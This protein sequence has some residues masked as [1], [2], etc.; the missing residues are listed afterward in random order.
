METL[1]VGTGYIRPMIIGG[2]RVERSY[3]PWAAII[4]IDGSIICGG[5]L[6]T[7]NHVLTAAHCVYGQVFTNK[8]ISNVSKCIILLR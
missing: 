5:S 8:C 2:N 1:S 7:K 4:N 6:I 3:M